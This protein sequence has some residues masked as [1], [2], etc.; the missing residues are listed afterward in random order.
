MAASGARSEP[1]LVV[2]AG[3]TASGKTALAIELA[4]TYGGE[5]ICA[6]SRTVYRGLD[7]GTAK[8]SPEEQAR[9]SHWGI[10]LAGPGERFTAAMFQQYAK[11]VIG[12]IRRRGKIPFLVGGTGLYVDVVLFDYEFPPEA[13]REEREDLGQMTIEALIKYCRENNVDLPNDPANRRHVVNSILRQGAIAKRREDL[14]PNT[15][16]VGIA[17]K[18]SKL[19]RR[20]AERAELIWTP[21]VMDEAAATAAQYGWESEAMT[22]NIYP[23]IRK[24]TEGTMSLEQAKGQF[25]TLDKRL[26]KRQMTWLRRNPY[27]VWLEAGEVHSYFTRVFS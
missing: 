27:I 6:D 15:V 2:I 11:E 18:K 16:V 1:P 12:D 8:P 4:E 25:V 21:A 3:P 23:L 17:T 9:V 24:V 26:A 5:I 7:V 19:A 13:S 22:G 20:I 10:D 14:I